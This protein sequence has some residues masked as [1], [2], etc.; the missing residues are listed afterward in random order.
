MRIAAGILLIIVALVNVFAA[1]GYLAGGAVVSGGEGLSQAMQEAAAQ[2]GNGMTAEQQAEIDN[3]M[4]EAPSGGGMLALG[5]FLAILAILQI[6]GAVQ[7]FRAKGAMLVM[8]VG[9]LTI[10]GEIWGIAVAGFGIMNL[11]GLLAGVL[12]ILAG[13]A[14]KKAV[15]APVG[16]APAGAVV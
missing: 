6:V 13:L 10:L 7:S 9:G 3:A 11:P 15:E 12:A 1:L 4:A 5:A 8:V 14:I 16:A 2:Q